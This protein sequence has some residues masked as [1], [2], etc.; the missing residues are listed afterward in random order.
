MLIPQL[1][2]W[3]VVCACGKGR[4][5]HVEC[6]HGVCTYVYVMW[7]VCV[8]VCVMQTECLCG[9]YGCAVCA[10]VGDAGVVLSLELW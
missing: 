4:R 3:D 6:H 5:P 1:E 8:C 2:P 10:R 9:G 7:T